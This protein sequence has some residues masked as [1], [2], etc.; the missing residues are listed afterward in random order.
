MRHGQL[1]RDEAIARLAEELS[2]SEA[3]RMVVTLDAENCEA[4]SRCQTDGDTDVEF[5]ASILSHDGATALTAYYYQA[6]REEWPEDLSDLDWDI[7]G[8]E[9]R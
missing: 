2:A 9:I 5:S 1:S 4:T 8:Y 7:H 3:V 6:H